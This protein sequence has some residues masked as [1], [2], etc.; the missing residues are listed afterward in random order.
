MNK[1]TII[2]FSLILENIILK[3]FSSSAA[4]EVK[5]FTRFSNLLFFLIFVNSMAK[6]TPRLRDSVQFVN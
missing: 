1:S 3:E 6:L 5:A 2:K 4:D